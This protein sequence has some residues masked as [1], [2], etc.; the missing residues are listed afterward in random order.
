M[1]GFKFRYDRIGNKLQRHRAVLFSV[2]KLYETE[3]QNYNK[4]E[5]AW[6]LGEGESAKAGIGG[7]KVKV[8]SKGIRHFGKSAGSALTGAEKKTQDGAVS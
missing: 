7:Q 5:L 6:K 2:S 1:Q 4:V 8:I 3:E